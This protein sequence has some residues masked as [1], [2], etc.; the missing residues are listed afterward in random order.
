M[1][2]LL[3]DRAKTWHLP[4]SLVMDSI[5]RI[6]LH[7]PGAGLRNYRYIDLTSVVRRTAGATVLSSDQKL[8]I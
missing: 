6:L 5:P 2:S 8:L 7:V 4:F 1:C 3:V